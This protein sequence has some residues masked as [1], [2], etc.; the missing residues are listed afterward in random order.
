MGEADPEPARVELVDEGRGDG[1]LP[2]GLPSLE[3][4]R[5]GQIRLEARALEEA[6]AVLE[7]GEPSLVDG[8]GELLVE[9]DVLEH[10]TPSGDGDR[11]AG[12]RCRF[13]RT[14]GCVWA[15]GG[16]KERPSGSRPTVS[17]SRADR[18]EGR[19]A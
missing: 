18:R 5:R 10:R 12:R 14:A 17:R 15:P 6:E 16:K 11:C 2:R 8:L 13:A 7:H 1:P 19:Y 9:V 4:H 3:D